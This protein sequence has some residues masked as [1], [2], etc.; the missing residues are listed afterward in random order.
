MTVTTTSTKVVAQGNGATTVWPYAFIIPATTDLI[1]S[2]INIAS[3]DLTI[4]AP[5]NYSV[6]GLGNP[7][8]GAVTYPLSGAPLSSAFEIVIERLVPELQQTDLVNQGGAYPQDI[9]DALDYLTMITQQLQDQVDRSI[10]FAV[11]TTGPLPLSTIGQR[12]NKLLGF[13]TDGL[14]IYVLGPSFVG[15]TDIGAAY[16]S[17]QAVASITTFAGSVISLTTGGSTVAGDGGDNRFRRGSSVGEGAF[18]DGSGVWWE[19]ETTPYPQIYAWQHGVPGDS[20]DQTAALQKIVDN[21]PIYGGEIYLRGDVQITGLNMSHKTGIRIIGAGG[22]ANAVG[23]LARITV[24]AGAI[25]TGNCAINC[26]T[27][28]YMHFENL[29]IFATDTTFNGRLIDFGP[30]APVPGDDAAYMSIDSCIIASRHGGSAN[31]ILL[32]L[33]GATDG[34]F[35]N[36]QFDSYGTC[37]KLQDTF[38]LQ[39][40]NQHN[41]TECSFTPGVNYPIR[42]SGDGITFNSCN[43]NPGSDGLGRAI[44]TSTVQGFRGFTVEGCT[45]YDSSVGGAVWFYFNLGAGLSFQHNFISTVLGSYVMSLGGY[46]YG[47]GDP[48]INGLLGFN[49][50][51]NDFEGGTAAITFAGTIVDKTNARGGIIGGNRV[52]NGV[53]S[54]LVQ[55]VV[56]AQQLVLLPNSLYGNPLGYGAHF[57]VVGLPAYASYAAAVAAGLTTGQCF[58]LTTTSALTVV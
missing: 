24:T 54:I 43:F 14:P 16:I 21:L 38:G 5:G 52:S 51:S 37:I 8:G 47:A 10:V 2:V 46:G 7:I 58:I 26:R 3:G 50:S 40:C 44:Q 36:I 49:I 28:A 27:T 13:D 48:Q 45:T 56:S 20:T 1:L 4:I 25:G 53:T 39:F 12:K 33:Y 29:Y 15:G 19:A 35:A 32:S 41:F 42:G 6:I 57:T 22:S 23:P 31:C 9:E 34:R 17:T 18:Q 11:D 30:V 55:N